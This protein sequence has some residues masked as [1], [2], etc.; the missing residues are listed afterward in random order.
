MLILLL[1][2]SILHCVLSHEGLD[3]CKFHIVIKC[4][5]EYS[6]SKPSAGIIEES[7]VS[8][9]LVELRETITKVKDLT[10][11]YE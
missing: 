10:T 9:V 3:K 4:L 2:F 6:S 11:C 7:A 8:Q 1:F 5:L